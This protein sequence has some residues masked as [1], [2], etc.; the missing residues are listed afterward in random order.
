MEAARHGLR[1]LARSGF[2]FLN[3]FEQ[4]ERRVGA[5]LAGLLATALI[6]WGV[7]GYI[8]QTAVVPAVGGL[9]R[10]GVVGGPRYLNPV[11]APLN[12]VD[13]DLVRL[14]YRGLMRLDENG[15]LMPDLAENIVESED[16]KTYEITLKSDSVWQDGLPIN[17]DDLV[18]TLHTIQNAAYQSPLKSNWEGVNIE[19]VDE[20][21][22]KITLFQP[23]ASFTESFTVGI[24][25]R[26]VWQDVPP[27]GFAHAEFNLRPVASGPYRVDKLER[28]AE[29]AVVSMMLLANERYGGEK[30]FI[31][32]LVFRFY[33]DESLL[34]DAYRQRAIDGI[35]FLSPN[36]LQSAGELS[37]L[38][39]YRLNLHR[40]FAVF[41]NMAGDKLKSLKAREALVYAIDREDLI[42]NTLAGA[43]LPAVG[44]IPTAA[45]FS[46]PD[47][48]PD[49]TFNLDKAQE[50]WA[51]LAKQAPTDLTLA[52]LDEQP[53]VAV[54]EKVKTDW[55]ALGVN[56]TVE[57]YESRVLKE[58]IIRNRNYDA[59]L[60]GQALKHNPDP[61][62]FWHSS[63]TKDPGLNIAEY[64]NT[65]VDKLL[66]EARQTFDL[67]I[68]TA[69]YAEFQAL[70]VSDAPAAFLYSPLYLYGVRH[71]VKGLVT[72]NFS[73]PE[74][75]FSFINSWYIKTR[76]ILSPSLAGPASGLPATP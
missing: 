36:Q 45:L 55:A 66:I 22:V 51:G 34:I 61:F 28:T 1:R 25:P 48:I 76:R 58:E 14:L 32:T 43:A 73:A 21:S 15:Q 67:A 49:R 40:Y 2:S 37:D 29:G 42:N 53:F 57:A 69:K 23:Y 74:D 18:F 35:T 17:A 41:F 56:V 24:L 54:A 11:L 8:S 12:E 52:T 44:P 60:F 7:H 71:S 19:K 3:T 31:P 4:R 10:E 68:R 65:Q 75:R 72:D 26:H 27:E 30:P 13:R 47:S 9:Y 64:K 16:H 63:Q 38:K 6:V 59:L 50:L 46:A 70:L 39:I 20:R 5:V 33:A 62:S